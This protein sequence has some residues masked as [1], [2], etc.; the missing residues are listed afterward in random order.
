MIILPTHNDNRGLFI[1]HGQELM[2]FF[3]F[4]QTQMKICYYRHFMKFFP[5][6]MY[7]FTSLYISKWIA[8]SCI[9]RKGKQKRWQ[10]LQYSLPKSVPVT[11]DQGKRE[12]TPQEG[13]I[14]SNAVYATF[15]VSLSICCTITTSMSSYLS[16][17]T[18]ALLW[19]PS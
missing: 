12:H 19:H 17:H 10:S 16:L 13:L 9:L 8:S 1:S 5:H 2:L 18:F 3:F 15:P 11:L 4:P 6:Q 14:M 7:C